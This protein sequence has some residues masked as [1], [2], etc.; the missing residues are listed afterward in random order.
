MIS[1]RQST[2]QSL[3]MTTSCPALNTVSLC[4]PHTPQQKE[5][6]C[7]EG[8]GSSGNLPEVQLCCTYSPGFKHLLTVINTAFIIKP[9]LGLGDRT[10]GEVFKAFKTFYTN[11]KKPKKMPRREEKFLNMPIT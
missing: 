1:R 9:S 8:A 4:S 10:G 6:A 2:E 11:G 7:F 3:R 5:A